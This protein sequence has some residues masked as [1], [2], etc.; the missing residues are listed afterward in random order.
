M[1]DKSNLD[2]SSVIF[3]GYKV[4]RFR[5]SG[6]KGSEYEGSGFKRFKGS[7]FKVQSCLV[8]INCIGVHVKCIFLR[9]HESKVF[10][11]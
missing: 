11:L 7:G 6:F 8:G 1:P 2:R 3:Q 4:Q 9:S 10:N 5:G